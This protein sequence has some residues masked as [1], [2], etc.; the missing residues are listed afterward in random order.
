MK[1]CENAYCAGSKDL[2]FEDG[3]VSKLGLSTYHNSSI[4]LN[5]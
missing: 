3:S 2:G 5:L 1:S 4:K